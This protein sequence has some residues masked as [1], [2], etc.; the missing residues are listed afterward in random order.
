MA[1][2]LL[3]SETSVK[4]GVQAKR[5]RAGCDLTYLARLIGLVI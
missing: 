2:Q 4:V 3:K 1:L 5:K